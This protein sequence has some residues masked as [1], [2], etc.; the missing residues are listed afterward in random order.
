ML[1]TRL[2][3]FTEFVR[4][5]LSHVARVREVI[6]TLILL[7]LIGAFIFSV[8]ERISFMD[9]VYFA[10][11][12]ALSVG[13]GD[14]SPN[15]SLGRFLSICIGLI[16]MLFIGITVAI[17]NRALAATVKKHEELLK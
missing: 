13:Y 4:S 7:I 1:S 15:T 2:H 10:F 14:I 16:G 3:L 9:S 11:V 5:F 6:A 8:A 17:A 12:T